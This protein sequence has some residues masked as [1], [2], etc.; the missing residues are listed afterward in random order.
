MQPEL[1]TRALVEQA[2]EQVKIKKSLPAVEKLRY[3]AFNEGLAAQTL[4]VG[5]FTEEGPTV[6]R[7]HTFIRENGGELTGKHHEIYLSD[8]RRAAPENWKTIIRQPMK[9]AATSI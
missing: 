6:E 5:P 2:I 8:I 1:I 4:H 9:M 3:E 7:V